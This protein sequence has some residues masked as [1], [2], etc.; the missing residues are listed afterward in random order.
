M[1]ASLAAPNPYV[2]GGSHY[3]YVLR[4]VWAGV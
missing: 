3:V 2:V 1:A 4:K